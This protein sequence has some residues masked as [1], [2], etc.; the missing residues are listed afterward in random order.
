[1]HATSGHRFAQRLTHVDLAA[2]RPSPPRGQPGRQRARQ[3]LHHALHLAQ[4][5][6]GGTQ[7]LDVLGEL[8]HAVHLHV[9]AAQ[10][11]G[12]AAFGLR[13]HHATQLIDALRRH[14]F[15]DLLLCRRR[16]VAVGGEQAG[17]Q[18]ALEI[19]EVHRLERLI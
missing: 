17:Q 5:L 18:P 13:L 3:R 2:P 11:F 16:F 19:V 8:R 1:V 6:T 14:R 10:L 15:R 12:G 4:L 7:E 9:V